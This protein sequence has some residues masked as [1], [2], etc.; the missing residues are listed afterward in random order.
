MQEAYQC[1][2]N[3]MGNTADQH[4]YVQN[5]FTAFEELDDNNDN[6]AMVMMQMAALATQSQLTTAS[7]AATSSSVMLAINQLVANQQAMMQQMMAYVNTAQN[8]PLANTVPISQF[9]IPTIGN[10]ALDRRLVSAFRAFLGATNV[11]G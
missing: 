5:A 4:R 2:L 11:P 7:T 8:T 1:R 6:A 10:T 3:A 9:T